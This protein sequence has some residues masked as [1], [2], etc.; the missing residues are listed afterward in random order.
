MCSLLAASSYVIFSQGL[1]DLS[2]LWVFQ[3]QLPIELHFVFLGTPS[4][5]LHYTDTEIAGPQ[6]RTM[7]EAGRL[8]SS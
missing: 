3:W 7:A 8:R 2:S 4:I 6:Q 5:P 1:F